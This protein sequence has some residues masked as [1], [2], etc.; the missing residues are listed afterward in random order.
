MER[1]LQLDIHQNIFYD[2]QCHTTQTANIGCSDAVRRCQRR[3]TRTS[4]SASR[5]YYAA[6]AARLKP[7]VGALSH[8][9][10]IV[11]GGAI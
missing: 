2:V 8:Y 9:R 10:N 3:C 1:T 4:G 11:N 7:N 5:K 6:L